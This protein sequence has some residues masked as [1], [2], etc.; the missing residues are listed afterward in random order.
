ML[1][2]KLAMANRGRTTHREGMRCHTLLCIAVFAS[3]SA[4]AE[5]TVTDQA[6]RQPGIRLGPEHL[7][8]LGAFAVPDSTNPPDW[9]EWSYGGHALA[10]RADGDPF[11]A[12]DGFPGSLYVAGN[13]QHETVG[14]ISIPAPVVT[15]DF[16]ALPRATV[17][18][19]PTD[20]TDGLLSATCTACTTCDCGAWDIGG[21][22]VL[23]SQHRVAWT[24]YDWYNA[25][26]EDLVSLGWSPMD[27]GSADG[28]WH[29][30]P[31]PNDLDSPFHNAKTSDYLFD[32]PAAFADAYLG[33]RRLISGYH[34][35]SGALGGSQGPTLIASAPWLEGSP[36]APGSDIPAVPLLYYRWF[37][38]CTDNEFDACDFSGYRVDDQW[39]GGA[40]ID[41]GGGQAVVIVGLKG[42]GDN[43]YGD[44]GVECPT[45]A[46]EPSRGYHSDPYE[47][48][49]L[50]YDPADL[51]D[52]AAG[53]RDPWSVR[54][55]AV[56]R[57]TSEVF[58]PDCG[59]LSAAAY[60]RD[61]GLLYVAEQTAGPWGETAIHVWQ[62]AR[63][64]FASGFEAGTVTE[65]S[66][67]TR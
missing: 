21:L 29:I 56:H 6:R 67:A 23:E 55:A 5:P 2:S 17:L 22:Q 35:E 43:C 7:T 33:G 34:R 9:D 32:A 1:M 20:P 25:A 14:E 4:A 36:P 65:W 37:L 66:D 62:V 31:R 40:W 44:P 58:D 11:G 26:A 53:L 16:A 64:L 59:F 49:M 45:P 47:P 50:F 18:A 13:A 51:A 3:A 52:V 63:H 27:L 46:C 54:P 41:S 60:D 30:G 38:D 48:Q 10:Y 57:P 24:I 28:V 39:G 15:A 42:L 61:R 19:A 8:Y 12:A